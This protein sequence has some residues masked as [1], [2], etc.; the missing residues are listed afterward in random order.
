MP[1]ADEKHLQARAATKQLQA[2]GHAFI[3]AA[4]R[5]RE[6][7]VLRSRASE[8][9]K[10]GH[11]KPCN[12]PVP[13]E[14]SFCD[15]ECHSAFLAAASRSAIARRTKATVAKQAKSPKPVEPG[16]KKPPR[17]RN[18]PRPKREAVE[19]LLNAG[20]RHVSVIAERVG[21][22]RGYVSS[23]LKEHGITAAPKRGG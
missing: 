4:G 23:I 20:Y 14:R 21:T 5:E 11:C 22:T 15:R 2:I 12:K 10:P 19:A 1:S 8:L 6:I 16:H 7:Q 9:T 18:S 3:D 13:P 17:T